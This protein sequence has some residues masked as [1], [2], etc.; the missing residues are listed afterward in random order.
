MEN[1]WQLLRILLL[2][3]G[4]YYVVTAV[5]P[6]VHMRS[7]L[8]VTGPKTD[9]WLVRTV[10]LMTLV[11]GLQLVVG[12]AFLGGSLPVLL[13]SSLGAGLALTAIDLIYVAKRVISPIYLADA[14]L[15][16]LLMLAVLGAYLLAR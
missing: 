13:V 9:L 15:E 12:V 5:W 3:Q 11:V 10:G 7:F 4:V 16:I 2:A 14:A 6:L 8:W 1:P